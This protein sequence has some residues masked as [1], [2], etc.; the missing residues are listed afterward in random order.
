MEETAP[1]EMW[2]K[3]VQCRCGEGRGGNEAQREHSDEEEREYIPDKNRASKR[4]K[5][6]GRKAACVAGCWVSASGNGI[7]DSFC[8]VCS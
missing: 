5:E 8:F 7:R 1:M 4:G 2:D 6:A 3:S